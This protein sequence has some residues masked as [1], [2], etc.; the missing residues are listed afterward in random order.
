MCLCEGRSVT[1]SLPCMPSDGKKMQAQLV[2][3][4]WGRCQLTCKVNLPAQHIA[5]KQRL[6]FWTLNPKPYLNH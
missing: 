1:S 6:V 2:L 4:I 3:S 5:H